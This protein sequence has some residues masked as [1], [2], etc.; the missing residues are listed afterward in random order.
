MLLARK[1]PTSD[2]HLVVSGD[3]KEFF[4]IHSDRTRL[5]VWEPLI[6][7]NVNEAHHHIQMHV[8]QGH[9]VPENLLTMI[10]LQFLRQD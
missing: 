2:V 1:D 9:K 6:S 5:R 8:Q 3:S 7:M 10:R 4:C